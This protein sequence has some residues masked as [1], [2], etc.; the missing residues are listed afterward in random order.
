MCAAA[1]T[2]SPSRGGSQTASLGPDD[3]PGSWPPRQ[4]RSGTGRR[5]PPR[6]RPSAQH[7]STAH[8]SR[9]QRT[10]S[11]VRLSQDHRR[12]A[13]PAADIG[14]RGTSA[15][16]RFH[17]FQRRDPV[18]GEMGDVVRPEEPLGSH[19]QVR[20]VLAP[21]LRRGYAPCR[22]VLRHARPSRS[23][24]CAVGR[25]GPALL[26]ELGDQRVP[27]NRVPQ[28]GSGDHPTAGTGD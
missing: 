20:V 15:Q 10:M 26:P 9:T 4:S 6:R 16:L 11:G 23:G 5:L 3:G 22:P 24:R 13:V 2:G 18:V 19:E 1:P 28:G 7:R 14:D 8:G 17:P 27:T 25:G 21:G 12:R